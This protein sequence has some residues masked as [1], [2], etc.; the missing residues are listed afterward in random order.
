LAG[1]ALVFAVMAGRR[2]EWNRGLEGF[3]MT[4][5]QVVNE[6]IS[7][8]EARGRLTER[9]QKLPEALP[10]RFHGSV[11]DDVVWLITAQESPQ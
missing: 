10:L 9:R 8:G 11:P 1:I 3:E 5:L 6:R 2:V 7:K 4:E